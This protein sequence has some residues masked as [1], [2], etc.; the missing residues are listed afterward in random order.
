M[1]F[2]NAAWT[3]MNRPSIAIVQRIS[4]PGHEWLEWK[5][6]AVVNCLAFQKMWCQPSRR[7]KLDAPDA[8]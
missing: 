4:R 6:A 7:Q 3:A 5:V 2:W 1:N 8:L